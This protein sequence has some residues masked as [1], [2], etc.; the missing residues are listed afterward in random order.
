MCEGIVV[1]RAAQKWMQR[2][3]FWAESDAHAN[4]IHELVSIGTRQTCGDTF[5]SCS[6]SA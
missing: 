3:K 2:Y 1:R 6:G 4:V 5:S